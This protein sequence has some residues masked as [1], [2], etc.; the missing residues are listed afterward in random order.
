MA[1]FMTENGR[2]FADFI[3]NTELETLFIHEATE[4]EEGDEFS[5][6]FG[7]DVDEI[8]VYGHI[9]VFADLIGVNFFI[10]LGDVTPEERVGL[11]EYANFFN[12]NVP[13]KM[14]LSTQE[15]HEFP[16]EHLR[17]RLTET[18]DVT[19]TELPHFILGMFAVTQEIIEDEILPEL[20]EEVPEETH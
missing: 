13:L 4:D 15:M 16:G 11:L 12:D 18:V 19:A 14:T 8:T 3:A 10:R 17:I 20:F 9:E 7:E 1:T 5:F 2:I 6:Y